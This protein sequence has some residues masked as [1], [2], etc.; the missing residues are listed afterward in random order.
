VSGDTHRDDDAILANMLA[1][2]ERLCECDD[3]LLLGQYAFL[4]DRI[5]A[6]IE[7]RECARAVKGQ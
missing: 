2:A 5:R 6:L 3:A 1:E 4:R 7:L